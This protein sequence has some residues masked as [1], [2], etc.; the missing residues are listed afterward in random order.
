MDSNDLWV[1]PANDLEA[2]EIIRLLQER[3][4]RVLVSRQRWGATWT[5][6]EPEIIEQLRV[7]PGAS[8]IGVEL[9]G[10]NPFG[11][12]NID[13]H[14]YR[15]EDR[16]QE[17]SSLEQVAERL[18]LELGRRQRM[19]AVNDRSYIAG[20]RRE[21]P[22]LTAEELAAVRSADRRAQGVTPEQEEQ[23][24]RDVAGARVENGRCLLE[25]RTRPISAHFDFLLLE[26]GAEEV[27]AT[28]PE[29]WQYTGPRARVFRE[30]EW[31]ENHWSGGE[32]EAGYF[33]IEN[34]GADS[35]ARMRAI[36]TP[37]KRDNDD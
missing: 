26:R 34:P 29:L 15:D 36:F 10:P 14:R 23:A 22:D 37:V 6:L 24:R 18:G 13:H 1:V 25:L 3:R 2:E 21:F 5:G 11:A 16:F 35:A 12:V 33:C 19:A 32:A 28:S 20:L 8:I 17:K 31:V 9:G 4:Q 30:Q 27:L 7:E